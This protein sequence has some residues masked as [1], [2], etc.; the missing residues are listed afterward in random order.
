MLNKNRSDIVVIGERDAILPFRALG[1][2]IIPMIPQAEVSERVAKLA[3]E[4]TIIF[5]TPDLF[6]Y[7]SPIME[8]H[9]KKPTPCFVALPL[10]KEE[11][12]IKRLKRLVARSVGIRLL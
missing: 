6:P 8:T 2:E 7:I 12:S 11:R 10:I 1:L 9:R 3:Q 4:R 5:F